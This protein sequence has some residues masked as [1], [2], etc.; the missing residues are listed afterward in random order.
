MS[1]RCSVTEKPMQTQLPADVQQ[2]LT[3]WIATGRYAS[4][5]EVL[6]DALRA[7]ADE[8][9]DFNAVRQAIDEVEAGDKG[10]PLRQAF[11]ELR[12]KH[13]IGRES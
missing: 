13:G 5:E 9:D 6:R 10:M 8:D 11:E 3:A 1:Q 7:L 2:N 12:N 4:E